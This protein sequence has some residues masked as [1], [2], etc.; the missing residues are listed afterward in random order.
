MTTQFPFPFIFDRQGRTADVD[1]EA[2][3][4]QMIEQVLFTNPGERVN[5]PDFGSGLLQLVHA[6][7]SEVL[8]AALEA[9][10]HGALQRWLGDVLTVHDLHVEALDNRLVVELSYSLQRTQEL[11]TERFERSRV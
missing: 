5:R 4:R 8:A 1:G 3:V 2:H 11:R 9:N 6:P 7:N 10:V